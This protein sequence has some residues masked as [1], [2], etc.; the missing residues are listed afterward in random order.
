MFAKTARKYWLFPLATVVC[1]SSTLTTIRL[2]ATTAQLEVNVGEPA[3]AG[4]GAGRAVRQI[5]G[6][7]GQELLR[8]TVEEGVG[9][10][11]DAAGS[12]LTSSSRSPGTYVGSYFVEAYYGYHFMASPQH[13]WFIY[14][15]AYQRWEPTYPPNMVI[16]RLNDIYQTSS[17]ELRSVRTY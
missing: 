2:D 5:L 10:A 1:L 14:N 9:R 3:Y 16:Y 7:V 12:R 8:S 15:F 6:F 4:R 17:G 13:G 11:F